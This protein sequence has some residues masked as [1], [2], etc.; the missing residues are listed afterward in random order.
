[1]LMGLAQCVYWDG[2]NPYFEP[3]QVQYDHWTRPIMSIGPGPI[4]LMGQAQYVYWARPNPYFEPLQ[5][6]YDDWARPILGIGPG[7]I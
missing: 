1:M 6:Q 4:S 7:P 3:F 5:V 2:F